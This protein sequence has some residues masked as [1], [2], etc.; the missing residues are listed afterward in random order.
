MFKWSDSQNKKYKRNKSLQQVNT[1]LTQKLIILP[2]E[3]MY[4]IFNN[5]CDNSINEIHR[6]IRQSLNQKE[7][8]LHAY[9]IHFLST[10]KH[11]RFDG[12]IHHSIKNWSSER[13]F[14]EITR[15]IPVKNLISE[16]TITMPQPETK[17]YVPDHIIIK[18]LK[19]K[20][21]FGERL[22]LNTTEI[23]HLTIS[24]ILGPPPIKLNLILSCQQLTYLHLDDFNNTNFLFAD[25]NRLQ[26]TTLKF[27]G[28]LSVLNIDDLNT[29]IKSQA[30]T[31]QKLTLKIRNM[32][33]LIYKLYLADT[34]FPKM[35]KLKILIAPDFFSQKIPPTLLQTIQSIKIWI[36][37]NGRINIGYILDQLIGRGNIELIKF[38]GR[39]FEYDR[40]KINEY[41]DKFIEQKHKCKVVR[42]KQ[43][44][45]LYVNTI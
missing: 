20:M 16:V 13:T 23:T 28:V 1:R 9:L 12:Y 29:F 42:I 3:I 25:L 30:P 40:L 17:I 37:W 41:V 18:K 21:A 8:N 43:H 2:Q 35:K 5:M 39:L 22:K 44:M 19:Y 26:L 45:R 14:C 15:F 32:A 36:G 6:L 33:N 31:I 11:L 34:E 10:L 7:Y 38:Y 4:K 27:S 24:C